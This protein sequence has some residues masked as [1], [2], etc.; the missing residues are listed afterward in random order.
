MVVAVSAAIYAVAAVV[1][2][3]FA[4]RAWVSLSIYS[5]QFYWV[6]G[7]ASAQLLR[8]GRGSLWAWLLALVAMLAVQFVGGLIPVAPAFHAA[9]MAFICCATIRILAQ[10]D[11]EKP[12]RWPAPFRRLGEISYSLYAIHVPFFVAWFGLLHLAR[13]PTSPL[14]SLMAFAGSLAAAALIYAWVERPSHL[15]AMAIKTA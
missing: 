9:W 15:R 2:P 5:F 13:L 14:W 12:L 1:G 11:S 6:L 8:K 4:S 7:A 10:R 3:H